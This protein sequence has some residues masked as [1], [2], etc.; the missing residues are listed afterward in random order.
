MYAVVSP[1]LWGALALAEAGVAAAG[2]AAAG[3]AAG[4]A[5][6][7][8]PFCGNT[9][10]LVRLLHPTPNPAGSVVLEQLVASTQ[11]SR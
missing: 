5:D 8:K 3:A 7:S 1:D 2:V 10:V 9:V 6:V 4:T 11:D